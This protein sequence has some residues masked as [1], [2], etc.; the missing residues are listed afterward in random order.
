MRKRNRYRRT[1]AAFEADD[2]DPWLLSEPSRGVPACALL[3]ALALAAC[4]TTSMNGAAA[5]GERGRALRHLAGQYRL[6]HRRGAAQ[7]ERSAGLQHARRGARPGRPLSRRRWPTSTR[8]SAIDP[9]YAQAYANRGLVYRETGK[10]DARARRLQQGDL[11]RSELRGRLS[12]PRHG[13]PRAEED[14][15]GAA[16]FQQGDRASGPTTRRPITTAACSTRASTST[17][18]PSTISPPPSGSPRSRPSPT[19]RAA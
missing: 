18:S 16:G 7:S 3:F 9:N 8:R 19:W 13:L 4:S 1:I 10:Y 17:A 2:T 14:Y 11:D 5:P 6:A 15:S 12:R